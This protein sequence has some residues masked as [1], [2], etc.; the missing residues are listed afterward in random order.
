[1]HH[2]AIHVVRGGDETVAT[3]AIVA[4]DVTRPVPVARPPADRS[5]RRPIAVLVVA[6]VALLLALGLAGAMVLPGAMVTIDPVTEAVGPAPLVIEVAQ[7]EQSRGTAEATSTVTA[8]G[9]Y[10]IL[11]PAAGDVVF[12]NWTFFPVTV[13]AGTF[14]AAGEQAFATQAEVV[15]LRGSL[16]ADGRI[17]AGE[18][19]VA[20][21]AAEPG[22]AANV[23]AEAIN[24]VVD[25]GIDAQLRGFPENPEPRVLNPEATTGGTDEAGIRFTRR[26]VDAAVEALTADLRRQVRDEVAEHPDEI[27]VQTELAEPT[28][29]GLDG[30]V[31][32]RDQAEATIEGTLSW[33]AWT[34]D[35]S[36]VREAARGQFADDSAQVPSGHA[37]LPESIEIELAEANV[38]DGVMRVAATATGRSAAEIDTDDVAQRIAGLSPDEAE[39]ALADLGSATVDTWPDWVASVPS[40]AWRIEVRVGEP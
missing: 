8:S 19:G 7:P 39:A 4:D 38:E 35:R 22:P 5:R 3:A 21:V 12:F 15:V 34:A 20:V 10:E 29:T 31:G 14:V 18:I 33:E 25:Q 11:E 36:E 17:A 1:V 6:V 32:T 2:A 30:L 28:I 16:T 26:D 37:L 9:E 40:M 24:V 23:A 13:P 27:V